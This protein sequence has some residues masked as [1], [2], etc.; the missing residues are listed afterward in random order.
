MLGKSRWFKRRK[1][2]GWGLVPKTWQGWVYI[3]IFI[4]PLILLETFQLLDVT[5]RTTIEIVVLAIF[6]LDLIE[7]MIM[8]KKD[9]RD[10]IHEALAE[11]N[12]LWG[13][14]VV[15]LLG[16]TYKLIFFNEF[17]WWILGTLLIGVV[18]KS[19]SNFYLE[20]KN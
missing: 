17:D 1:Y 13:M 3:L 6:I 18:I 4:V 11:R 7:M 2:G 19:I 14:V 5:S 10:N 8:F 12:A 9:E 20:K 16:F 15:L